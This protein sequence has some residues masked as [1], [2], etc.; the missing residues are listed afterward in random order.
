MELN[1]EI[2]NTIFHLFYM[3]GCKSQT[4]QMKALTT[5][6]LKEIENHPALIEVLEN[7]S[8]I[9]YFVIQMAFE[10]IKSI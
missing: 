5:I 2:E 7:D 4:K 9:K 1:K 3:Y 8:Q 10:N 6:C